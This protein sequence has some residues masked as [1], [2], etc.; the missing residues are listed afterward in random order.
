MG[1]IGMGFDRIRWVELD[2]DG[3]GWDRQDEWHGAGQD[4]MGIHLRKGM[5]FGWEWGFR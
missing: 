5:G 3:I 4:G 1:W 2:W